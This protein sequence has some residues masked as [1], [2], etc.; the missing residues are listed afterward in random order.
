MH[1]KSLLPDLLAFVL[2][3]ESVAKVFNNAVGHL[4]A[5]RAFPLLALIAQKYLTWSA[6]CQSPTHSADDVV[7]GG[8]LL[9]RASLQLHKAGF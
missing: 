9:T 2:A 3:Q 5:H 4:L 6:H 1:N 7:N 8:Y